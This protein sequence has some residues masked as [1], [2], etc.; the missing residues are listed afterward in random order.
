MKTRWQ[1]RYAYVNMT[2][3]DIQV[4]LDE[5][6]SEG[7]ELVSAVCQEYPSFHLFF[8]RPADQYPSD[9]YHVS[10]AMTRQV[11]GDDKSYDD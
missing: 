6:E 9:E 2:H 3:T 10:G 4:A 5:A 1:H 8:K 7:W 11:I